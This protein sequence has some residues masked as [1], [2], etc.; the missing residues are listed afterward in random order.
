[1]VKHHNH[2]SGLPQKTQPSQSRP[3]TRINQ[4]IPMMGPASSMASRTITPCPRR[5]ADHKIF[6]IQNFQSHCNKKI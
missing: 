5:G 2:R 3:R 4:M 6:V 1:L